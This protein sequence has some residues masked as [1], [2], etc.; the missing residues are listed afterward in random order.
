MYPFYNK[1]Q[2]FEPIAD[3]TGKVPVERM[4]STTIHLSVVAVEEGQSRFE[5]RDG[6]RKA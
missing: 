4:S 3:L 5:H 1:L 2:L 6:P